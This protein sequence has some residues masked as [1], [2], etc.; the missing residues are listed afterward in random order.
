MVPRSTYMYPLPEGEP[1]MYRYQNG[2]FL[3][4][5]AFFS[6]PAGGRFACS[7]PRRTQEARAYTR[8]ERNWTPG[9][10]PWRS[11]ENWQETTGICFRRRARARQDNRKR[12]NMTCTSFFFFALLL[13]YTALPALKLFHNATATVTAAVPHYY[14]SKL[15]CIVTAADRVSACVRVH[16][17]PS[18]LPRNPK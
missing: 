15:F 11:R 13:Y 12:H 5:G 2:L 6:V 9:R 7:R 10:G 8:L 18:C 14:S 16:A 3:A 17:M 4:H 1:C